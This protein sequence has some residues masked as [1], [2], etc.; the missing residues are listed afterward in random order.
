LLPIL[1][2]NGYKIAN[3][4]VLARISREELDHLLRGFG[5][6]PYYVEGDD[7]KTIHQL[8]AGTLDT[9]V[10]EIRRAQ[11]TARRGGRAERP[12]WPMIVLRSPKGWTGPKE[13]DGKKTEGFWRSHQVPMGELHENP[14]HLKLLNAWLRSSS[15]RAA[16]SRRSW[17]TWP[18]RARGGWAPIRTPTAAFC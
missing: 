12:R 3:P 10:E 1:H 11:T 14:A 13:V 15:M 6:T 9:V 16:D 17:P 5:H 2:L 18:R 4:C 7:P 8:M